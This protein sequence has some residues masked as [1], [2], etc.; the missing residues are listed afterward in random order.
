VVQKWQPHMKAARI[1]LT[2]ESLLDDQ[3]HEGAVIELRIERVA[4]GG[5]CIARHNG[6]AV[7]VRHSLPGEL[8]RAEVTEIN[9]RFLRADVVE[10]LEPSAA[11]VTPKC[12]YAGVCGGCDWQHSSLEYQR[13]LKAQVVIEQMGHLAGLTELNGKPIEE[14]LVDALPGETDGLG[15]RTRNRFSKI[16]DIGIGMKMAR[17]HSVVEIDHCEIAVPGS[18]DLALS[19]LHL[20]G[21]EVS[22][23]MSSTDQHVVVDKRGGPW[24][25]EQVFNRRWRIHA[26]SFWQVHK[27]APEAF[28]NTVREFASLQPGDSLLD[29]YAGSGLFAASLAS[30]VGESGTVVAVESGV[31]AVRDARRSCSDLPQLELV[32]ADVSRWITKCDE[33]FTVVV[34]DPPRAGAGLNV[35][36]EISQLAQKAIIYVACDPSAL[37]RDTQYLADA[38]WALQKIVAH[39]AFPMTSHVE[40]IARFL[41]VQQ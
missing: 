40:C 32:T 36:N 22:T 4:N 15:W 24:L 23:A 9:K 34:L 14:F 20:S 6:Q 5:F 7:F 12:S 31:D 1:R 3:I 41:P 33:L 30:D 26:G 28:V 38:G 8:V 18:I 17:S 11:R 21:D 27:N 13:E 2:T 19:A 25:E 16:G 39:D 29:L 37:A 35:I 10:V